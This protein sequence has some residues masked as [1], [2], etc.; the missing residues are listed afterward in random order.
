V[1]VSEIMRKKVKTISA[2]QT[3]AAAARLLKES[4]ISSIVVT[5]QG[6]PVGIVTERDIVNLVAE[7]KDPAS[8]SIG[9]GMTGELATIGPAT[10]LK[11]AAQLMAKRQVRH[12]PV[13][14][15]DALV[16]MISIRDLLGWMT[17]QMEATPDMWMDMMEAAA[18]E[19]P[20]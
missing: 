1:E 13:V 14:E 4:R 17:V 6:R 19:W 10:E 15:E 11:E 18:V 12:L 3:F 20:H 2:D 8:T 9:E 5:G 7:G 16:G